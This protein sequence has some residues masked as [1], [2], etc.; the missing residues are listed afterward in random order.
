MSIPYNYNLASLFGPKIRQSSR[1][2]LSAS[3]VALCFSLPV[4][5][6]PTVAELDQRV[7]ALEEA[8][9]TLTQLLQAQQ[10]GASATG[11]PSETGQNAAVIPAGYQMG[12][13]YLDVFTLESSKSDL[14]AMYRDPSKLPLGP[15]GSP[16][17]SALV[18]PG[19]GFDYGALLQHPELEGFA[20]ADA[21]LGLSW[22]GFL[23]VS[24]GGPHTISLQLKRTEGNFGGSCRSVLRMSG[25]VVADAL[26]RYPTTAEKLDVSQTEQNLEPGMYEISLWTT[27]AVTYRNEALGR[28]STSL[29]VS[30][31]GDRA[32]KQIAPE[33]FGVQP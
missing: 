5:A 4:Q 25:K 33:R 7:R 23:E 17:G 8:V 29:L 14:E 28:V 12:A 20:N 9:Q 6:E 18:E 22:T 2:L 10:G 16:V 32:P 3:C 24:E 19:S 21:L 26:G 27:C 15:T 13:L 1:L 31:P 11:A 30:G